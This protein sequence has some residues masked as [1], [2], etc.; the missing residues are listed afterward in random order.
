MKYYII[1]LHKDGTVYCVLGFKYKRT[2]LDR[3]SFAM[4]ECRHIMVVDGFT[5]DHSDN[6]IVKRARNCDRISNIVT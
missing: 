6:N 2:F 3:L 5:F 1:F 4:G